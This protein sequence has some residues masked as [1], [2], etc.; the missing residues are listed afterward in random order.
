MQHEIYTYHNP[1]RIVFDQKDIKVLGENEMLLCA[2]FILIPLGHLCESR[3]P[4]PLSLSGLFLSSFAWDR[5]SFCCSCL[6]L[7][8]KVVAEQSNDSGSDAILSKDSI[9]HSKP[10][11]LSLQASLF[12]YRREYV[13]NEQGKFVAICTQLSS[14]VW[15]SIR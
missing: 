1:C 6:F 3:L 12:C 11:Y 13:L 2:V 4:L 15:Y 10:K 7:V 5:H 9:F 14:S 8:L